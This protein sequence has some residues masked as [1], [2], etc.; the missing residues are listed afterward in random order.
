MQA[1]AHPSQIARSHG[2]LALVPE[3]CE[4]CALD[5][6]VRMVEPLPI[7]PLHPLLLLEVYSLSQAKRV[8]CPE[9]EPIL[10]MQTLAQVKDSIGPRIR[11][12]ALRARLREAPS[13]IRPSI[14]TPQPHLTT[15]D[16]RACPPC[17]FRPTHSRRR[18]PMLPTI[19]KRGY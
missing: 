9:T 19:C 3:R 1:L 18:E 13:S 7:N 5:L 4:M 10:T 12:L 6:E 2:V 11:G 16:D 8:P 14:A 15:N 17:P